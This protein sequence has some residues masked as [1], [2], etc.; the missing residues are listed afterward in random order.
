MKFSSLSYLI[1]FVVSITMLTSCGNSEKKARQCEQMGATFQAEGNMD[2]AIACYQRSYMYYAALDM[3]TQLGPD[4]PTKYTPKVAE[5]TMKMA[6]CCESKHNFIGA[7]LH[8]LYSLK[9]FEKLKQTDS[10][11]N[12]KILLGYYYD[13]A[14]QTE[15]ND[16]IATHYHWDGMGYML[17]AYRAVDSLQWATSNS[18]N[19]M[20]MALLCYLT[21]ETFSVEIKDSADAQIFHKKYT[22]LYYKLT[23]HFPENQ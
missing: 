8:T 18:K 5:V 21:G 3:E 19:K 22:D 23:G 12:A 1:L 10:C 11:I 14:A 2:S 9:S 17:A 4:D 13:Q 6:Q 16:S 15:T 7:V 20:Q